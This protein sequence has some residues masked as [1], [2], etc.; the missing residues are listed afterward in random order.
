MTHKKNAL[1]W[2]TLFFA[3]LVGGSAFSPSRAAADFTY[4]FSGN[5]PSYGNVSQNNSS[6]GTGAQY[7]VTVSNPGNGTVAFTFRNGAGTSPVQSTIA[8]IYFADG[9]LLGAPSISTSGDAAFVTA[10]SPSTLPSA[11]STFVTSVQFDASAVNPKPSNGVDYTPGGPTNGDTVTLTFALQP[12]HTFNDVVAQLSNTAGP[13]GTPQ[14]QIG[15]H[16]I[17]FASGSSESFINNP[18]QPSTTPA[19][20][21]LTL[22]LSGLAGIGLAWLRRWRRRVVPV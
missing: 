13:S 5:G 15:I 6:D 20:A 18:N 14:L 21:T 10:G 2:H 16:V 4:D 7:T 3:L 11:P 8:N 9:T 17:N 1:A 19:P 12:G 22:A